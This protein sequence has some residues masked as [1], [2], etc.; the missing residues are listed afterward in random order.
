M[1][2]SN[3]FFEQK[4]GSFY[5]KE[6][7]IVKERVSPAGCTRLAFDLPREMGIVGSHS[8]PT[9]GEIFACGGMGGPTLPFQSPE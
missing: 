1:A 6:Y 8:S 7:K 9:S 5:L 3:L 2:F 4:G